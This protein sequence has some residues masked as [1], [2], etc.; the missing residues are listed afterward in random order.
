MITGKEQ[1]VA[2]W[3]RSSEEAHYQRTDDDDGLG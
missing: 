3:G 1:I 2:G